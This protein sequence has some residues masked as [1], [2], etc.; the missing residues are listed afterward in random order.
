MT[1]NELWRKDVSVRTDNEKKEEEEMT[2]GAR[3]SNPIRIN[4]I[5]KKREKSFFLRR[6]F[7]SLTSDFS[8][9]HSRGKM[10]LT[11]RQRVV[12]FFSFYGSRGEIIIKLGNIYIHIIKINGFEK[13]AAQ[14]ENEKR[15]TKFNDLQ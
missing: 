14:K 7:V 6:L 10:E 5:G 3:C 12:L 2:V 9:N 13:I 15:T 4:P 1:G 8:A 11:K